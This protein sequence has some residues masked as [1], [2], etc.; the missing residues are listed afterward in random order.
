MGKQ[1]EILLVED[2]EGDIRLTQE[3]LKESKLDNQLSIVKDGEEALEFLHK[4]GKYKDAATPDLVLL[5][6]NLPKKNG[7]EVLEEVKRDPAL[8]M[9]PIVVLTTSQ[10]EEDIVKVYAEHANCY[11]QKPVDFNRF[12]EVVHSVESFWFSIVKLPN[13]FN[14]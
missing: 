7:R 10:A 14:R 11:I 1:V 13:R 8:A 4:K 3:A 12:M 2:N 6:L 5:D 9:I